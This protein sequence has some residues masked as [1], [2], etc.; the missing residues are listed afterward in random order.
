MPAASWPEQA[1]YYAVK[2]HEAAIVEELSAIPVESE[3]VRARALDR[4]NGFTRQLCTD[5]LSAT[6]PELERLLG[7]YREALADFFYDDFRRSLGE[8]CWEVVKESRVAEGHELG[9]KI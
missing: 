2:R 5:F 6:T 9:Y 3:E 8:L 7:V 1:L 4:L